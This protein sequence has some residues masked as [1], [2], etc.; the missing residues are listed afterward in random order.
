MKTPKN[1]QIQASFISK[2]RISKLALSLPII[3]INLYLLQ[4][5]AE[6]Q[7]IVPEGTTTKV[8]TP[9][10]STTSEI[11]GGNLSPLSN[12]KQNLFHSFTEFGLSEN[13]IANFISNPNIL[14]IL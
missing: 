13:Q 1:I 7:S 8:N 14:N 5:K 10:G 9:A 2:S 3:L 6:A 4:A 11:T 12:G